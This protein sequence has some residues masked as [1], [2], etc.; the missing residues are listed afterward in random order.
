MS[1]SKRWFQS[2]LMWTGVLAFVVGGLEA[3]GASPDM[4]ESVAKY[5]LLA[6]GI[7]VMVFRSV[8]SKAITG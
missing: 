6:V 5:A 4:P 7:L 1:D 8:T 2:K 3:L